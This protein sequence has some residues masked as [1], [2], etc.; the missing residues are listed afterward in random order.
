MEIIV[1]K[2]AGFCFGV[3]RAVDTVYRE[4]EKGG[5]LYTYGPIIHNEEVIRELTEK[6]VV[7]INDKEELKRLKAD[8]EGVIKKTVII[9]SHGAQKEVHDIIRK[10]GLEL[11]DAT[12]PFVK[13]IHKI[14]REESE[15]GKQIVIVG[16]KNH[17]EVEGIMGWCEGNPIVIE[18]R[19][20][21]EKLRAYRDVP[22]CVVAQTTFNYK[23]FQDL[24]EIISDCCYDI[25]AV[26]TICSATEQRQTE[27]LELS[28]QVD[29][30]L[31]VGGAKSSNTQKLFEICSGE[32]NNTYFIQTAKDLKEKDFSLVSRLGVTAGASTPNNIIEE[33]LCYVRI[34]FWRDV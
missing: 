34:N 2:S 25:N 13:K 26:H 17:P 18:N 15:K 1:A 24:V 3:K 6:G 14:V 7:I 29:A 28:K 20:E 19:E 23:N 5:E 4:L 22:V 27:A 9:R 16:N 11:V 31:V 32:C 33:I 12:C 30:M 21:A 8:P 10:N